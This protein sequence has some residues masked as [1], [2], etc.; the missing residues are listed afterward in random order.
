MS[1]FLLWI[2]QLADVCEEHEALY[3]D[4]RY[5][6]IYLSDRETLILFFAQLF[7]ISPKEGTE[8]RRIEQLQ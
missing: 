2:I 5:C 3:G 6:G 1:I 7:I 4:K 8:G